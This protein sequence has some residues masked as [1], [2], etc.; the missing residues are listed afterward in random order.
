MKKVLLGLFL[1]LGVVSFSALE[2]D[3]DKIQKK[4]FQITLQ[5]E[6]VVTLEKSDKDYEKSLFYIL[7]PE[8]ETAK[9][10]SQATIKTALKNQKVISTYETEKAYVV[11]FKEMESGIISYSVVDKQITT[12][13]WYVGI[14]FVPKKELS[15]NE[16]NKT[17][18][19][20]LDEA[21]NF[22]K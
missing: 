4:N 8:N 17:F 16:L 14:I 21:R 2:I 22:I 15:E 18:S 20:L 1:I 13:G 10:I 5:D 11:K 6:V 19:N 7:G 9:D 3:A 12:K